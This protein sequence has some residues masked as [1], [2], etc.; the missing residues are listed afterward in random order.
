[1][2]LGSD[3]QN[4]TAGLVALTSPHSPAAEAFRA[5]RT[6][7]QFSTLDRRLKLL[8]VTSAGPRE[9]KSTILAN[10]AVSMAE[11]G[12]RV[13]AVDADLRRPCLHELFGCARAPGLSD[14]VLAGQ[15]GELPLQPTSVSGLRLLAAGTPPPNPSEVLGS[16]RT[17][18]LLQRVAEE[19]DLAL[20]DS[21]PVVAVT[22]AVVLASRMDGVLFVVSSGQTRRDLARMARA[23]LERVNA[24][25]LGVVLNNVRLDQSVY[26]YYSTRQG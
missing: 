22:D 6:N 9:G 17:Q 24:R 4:G 25:I 8:Q 1:M 12:Q 20:V 5:L 11:S 7:I 2:K 19:C 3:K 13:V 16:Q 10:L 26:R 18:R 14:A 21:P 15:E 23:Q